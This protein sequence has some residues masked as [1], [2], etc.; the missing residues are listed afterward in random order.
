MTKFFGQFSYEMN[1]KISI[2]IEDD[3]NVAYAYLLKDNDV[4]GDVWLYN[5]AITP[6]HTIWDKDNMPFLNSLDYLDISKMIS[7]ILSIDEVYVLW[8]FPNDINI[9]AKIFIRDK[10]IAQLGQ[11]DFP[12]WSTSVIKD[13]PLAKKLYS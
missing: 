9:G 8:T 10:L 3:G 12:G 4:I 7:P 11:D 5:Q 2:I 1:E 6:A 13:G